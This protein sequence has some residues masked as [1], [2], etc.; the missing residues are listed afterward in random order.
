MYLWDGTPE[1][2]IAITTVSRVDII[3]RKEVTK[4]TGI[5]L[6]AIVYAVIWSTLGI[7]MILEHNPYYHCIGQC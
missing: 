5:E 7:C 6:I 3:G 1:L 2:V 4:M